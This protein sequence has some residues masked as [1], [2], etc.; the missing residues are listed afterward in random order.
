[1][2]K[3]FIKSSQIK[4]NKIYIQDEN[5]NHIKNVFR[6][7]VGDCITVCNEETRKNYLAEIIDINIE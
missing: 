7:K 6:K 2:P 3:F 4:E 5:V 1:M